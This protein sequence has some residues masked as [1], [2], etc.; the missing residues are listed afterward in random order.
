MSMWKKLEYALTNHCETREN[1]EDAELRS[2]ITTK[3]PTALSS[4]R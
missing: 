1:H 2:H 3:R 4:T